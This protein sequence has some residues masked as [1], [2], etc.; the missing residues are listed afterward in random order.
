MAALDVEVEFRDP[1]KTKPFCPAYT[2]TRSDVVPDEEIG[3]EACL[4]KLYSKE[5]FNCLLEQVRGWWR[6]GVWCFV[7]GKVTSSGNLT[8]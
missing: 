8:R 5:Q 3:W 2:S 6:E 7:G 4:G 1:K